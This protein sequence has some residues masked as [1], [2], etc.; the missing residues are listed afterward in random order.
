LADEEIHTGVDELIT[1]LKSVDKITVQEAAQKL[2]VSAS[3]IQ[4]W[5]DFLVEEEIVGIEYKFTKP[6]IYLNKQPKEKAIIVEDENPGSIQNFK[7]EFISRA[8]ERQIPDQKVGFFWKNHVLEVL[9]RR[10]DFFYREARKR[11]LSNIE[12]LWA[13]YSNKLLN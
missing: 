13:E 12:P 1:F 10:K 9:T 3:L 6:I 5:V 2:G 8:K 11:G 4:S 7:S